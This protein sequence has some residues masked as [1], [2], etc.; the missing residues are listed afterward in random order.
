MLFWNQKS[1]PLLLVA[2]S[3]GVNM[4]YAEVFING[5][6]YSDYPGLN[7]VHFTNEYGYYRMYN[8]RKHS[9]LDGIVLG[10]D[11]S[12]GVRYNDWS[13]IS[14]VTGF[15]VNNGMGLRGN[16]TFEAMTKNNINFDLSGAGGVSRYALKGNLTFASTLYT[17]KFYNTS[18]GGLGIY[19]DVRYVTRSGINIKDSKH[20][21][22]RLEFSSRSNAYQEISGSVLNEAFADIELNFRTVGIIGGNVLADGKTKGTPAKN[23]LNFYDDGTIKGNVKRTADGHN[24]LRMH[25]RGATLKLMGSGYSFSNIFFNGSNTIDLAS[26]QYQKGKFTI[27]STLYLENAGHF[28]LAVDPTSRGSLGEA[29]LVK[30]QDYRSPIYSDR[31]L[32]LSGRGGRRDHSLSLDFKDTLEVNKNLHD[33]KIALAT[34]TGGGKTDTFRI[35]GKQKYGYN[36]VDVILR[37]AY[38]DKNG[39]EGRSHDYYTYFI[40]RIVFGP[41]PIPKPQPKPEPKPEPKPDP[42][43]Q[44]QPKPPVTPP[45]KPKPPKPVTPP[46]PSKPNPPSPKP[47]QPQPP[48]PPVN[49]QP[50]PAPQPTPPEVILPTPMPDPNDHPSG[51]NRQNVYATSSALFAGYDLYLANINSLNKRLGELRSQSHADGV[52]GR[53]FTG[54]QSSRFAVALDS[55]Y[56]T[57]QFG[58]DKNLGKIGANQF[59]GV[60]LSYANSSVDTNLVQ[61]GALDKAI[62]HAVEVALYNS[63]VQDGASHENGWSNGLYSDTIGK[64]SYIMTNAQMQEDTKDYNFNN[65]ALSLGQEVGYRFL[66]GEDKNLYLD[67]QVELTFAYLNAKDFTQFQGVFF[68]NAKQNSILMLRSRIGTS[69]GYRFN[70]SEGNIGGGLYIGGFYSYDLIKGGDIKASTNLTENAELAGLQST[71]RMILNLGGNLEIHKNT[72]LYLDFEKSFG[73]KIITNYQINLGFRYS[74]GGDSKYAPLKNQDETLEDPKGLKN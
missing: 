54:K 62:S 52:W 19:G 69:L 66:F 30:N 42:K 44:P 18:F 26:R 2:L 64:F 24:I 59:I 36:M 41:N 28:R 14:G 21:W 50:D 57:A 29:Y 49:P 65:I 56:T 48:V 53:V 63:Y 46:T 1:S 31:I 13:R 68:L 38:T 25:K 27:L 35:S 17:G 4:A 12:E 23:H 6:K 61:S 8:I 7:N 67:P 71:G 20:T 51:I 22:A 33:Q 43:P 58:Y 15:R 16:I 9:Y 32:V 10:D 70:P 39:N 74:F 55:V 40:D 47:T 34:V 45:S 72:K 37:G 5:R 11:T 60:A 73:G 3:L